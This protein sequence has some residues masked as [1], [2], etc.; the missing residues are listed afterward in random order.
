[1]NYDGD[2]AF[3]SYEQLDRFLRVAMQGMGHL[4]FGC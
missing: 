4:V 3:T 1:M 2:G